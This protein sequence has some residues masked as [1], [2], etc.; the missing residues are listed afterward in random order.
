MKKKL[1]YICIIVWGSISVS[2]YASEQQKP[3]QLTES[4]KEI[5]QIQAIEQVKL[6]QDYC[7]RIAQKG[8]AE[9]LKGEYI[10]ETINLFDSTQKTIEVSSLYRNTEKKDIQTYLFR[11][12]DLPYTQVQI[13]TGNIL[14]THPFTQT[15]DDWYEGETTV[16]QKFKAINLH[17]PIY[18]DI[19]LRQI[20]VYAQ[21][22]T[23]YGLSN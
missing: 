3:N 18:T 1:I 15:G 19:T 23:L 7:S 20:K 16:I 2:I 6:F 9:T 13:T 4:E 21:K 8:D 22:K 12:K 11:L 17:T 10:T 14:F 5:L